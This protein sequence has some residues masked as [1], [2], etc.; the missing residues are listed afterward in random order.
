MAFNQ[1]LSSAGYTVTFIYV[2]HSKED[3]KE[4]SEREKWRTW[5]GKILS[6]D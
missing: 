5:W 3:R 4:K 2:A 1:C 6:S